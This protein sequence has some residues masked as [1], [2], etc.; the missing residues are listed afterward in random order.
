V[1]VNISIDDITP[2]PN[3]SL[4]I[5]DKCFDL[6]D[7][8]PDIKFTLFIP[9]AYYRTMPIPSHIP[10]CESPMCVYEHSDFCETLLGLSDKNFQFGY[11]GLHHGIRGVSNNDEFRNLSYD[12]AYLKFE[13]MESIAQRSGIK[14]RMSLIFRPPAWKM[15]PDSIRAA[16]DFGFE[17]LALN[18]DPFYSDGYGGEQLKVSDVVYADCYP[19]FIELQVLEKNEILYH[20]CEWDKNHLNEDAVRN[21]VNF[22]KPLN[23]I[24]F[25]FIE[26]L[27]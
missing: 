8:F 15:S 17:V 12:D 14:D 6:I 18:S 21:L 25:C 4:K 10:V 11:H 26:D 1:R 2:H 27:L 20:A 9:M 16:R 23:D 7:I 24:E 22:L 19:P 3:S 5:L 13:E